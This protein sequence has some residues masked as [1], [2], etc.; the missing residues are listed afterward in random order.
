MKLLNLVIEKSQAHEVL[1]DIALKERIH[2]VD[3][4]TE[5]NENNFKLKVDEN[6]IEEVKGLCLIDN[7]SEKRDFK[8]LQEKLYPLMDYMNIERKL[9]KSLLEA[10]YDFDV[11]EDEV[12]AVY[13][14]L[15]EIRDRI[16]VL[17]TEKSSLQAMNII[18]GIYE[19]VDFSKMFNLN[20]FNITFGTL[21]KE[22]MERL[23][24]NYDN[25]Y[26]AI[27]HIGRKGNHEIYIV[28]SLKELALETDRILRSV[29]FE[30]IILLEPYLDRPGK[31]IEKIE[32]RMMF[33]DH[34]LEGLH[35]EAKNYDD[36]HGEK[37]QICYSQLMLELKIAKMKK[38]L[39]VTSNYVYITGWISEDDCGEMEE[40]FNRFGSKIVFG[41]REVTD[42]SHRI[43]PPTKLKNNWLF[44]PFEMLVH[45]Y[46]TPSYDELDPTAFVGIAYMLL[47]GAMF[48]DVGQGLLLMVAGYFIQKKSKA[49]G[50]ILMRI[51]LFSM[52]FGF[53][54]DS[55]FGYEHLLSSLFPKS[56]GGMFLR[57][58]EN[59]NTILIAGVV[60]GLVFLMISYAYS[61]INKLKNKD[62]KEGL[63]GRNGLAGIVLFI[64]TLLLVAGSFL[65]VTWVPVNL[66]KVIMVVMVILMVV[67]EPLSNMIKKIKPLHHEPPSEYYVE[68]SFELL[69]TFLGMLSNTLS[70][71]RV[72]AFALNHVG[73][74]MAFHTIANMMGS[75]MGQISM[76]IVGNVIVIALEG[77]IV[78]IQGLRLVYYEM[79]SKYYTGDGLSF[80]PIKIENVGGIN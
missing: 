45:M 5:I 66:M 77:L 32:E 11:L 31:M 69:E 49:P 2:L 43:K 57:P 54:Y 39:A 7:F 34:E 22:N 48:G 21:S 74:F 73:L 16:E 13:D 76:F 71:I 20:F 50:G 4:I 24:K 40:H 18:D 70:F 38:Q 61:V 15:S 27:L 58:I 78:L 3:S 17:E 25:I 63:F 14:E 60:S 56:M 65:K 35:L 33:V 44:K 8:T 6:L 59:I 67:R 29:Y 51:G 41:T 62:I 64:A 36:K 46:G 55:F 79:F 10:T 75:V 28:I 68:S 9:D 47:F 12:T 72:G 53:F 52:I 80:E 23:T 30:E 19:D 42:V 37:L 1:K 26:A